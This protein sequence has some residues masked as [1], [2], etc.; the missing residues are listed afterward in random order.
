MA[1]TAIATLQPVWDC[2]WS[3][4][5]HRLTGVSDALQPESPWVCA[6]EG[7]R[8][9]VQDEECRTCQHWEL[10]PGATASAVAV[11]TQLVAS[12]PLTMPQ[13][14]AAVSA[15]LAVFGRLPND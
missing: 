1:N 7:D 12:R 2:R 15:G 10:S 5:G 8:R 6:R 11:A 14:L 13:I 4:P 3:R 9:D